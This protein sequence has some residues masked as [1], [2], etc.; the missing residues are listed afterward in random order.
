M[1]NPIV[2]IVGRPNVGK[3]T[4]LNRMSGERIAITSPVPGTTRDR[5]YAPVEW[6]GREFTIV[7]T[8]GLEVT[9]S[10][11]MPQRIKG[12]VEIAI[13]EADAILFLVDAAEGLLP[14]DQD[15]ASFLRRSG[16]P[17]LL[18]A[19][20]VDNLQRELQAAEFHRLGLGEPLPVSA[21]H[22]RG[23][24]EMLDRLLLLLPAPAAE[25]KEEPGIKIA[26]VGRTNVGK[27]MLLNALLGEERA[28]VSPT[29]GT[30][31]DA[32]DSPCQYRGE[33]LLLIDTAGIRRRGR[34]EPGVERYSVLRAMRAIER[35]DVAI[36]VL[37]APVGMLAQ[38]LH[39]A[40][41]IH[42]AFKGAVIA[43]NKWD[44]MAERDEAGYAHRVRAQLHFMPYVPVRFVSALT[45][46][47]VEGLL[48]AALEVFR[49]R[50]RRLPPS[51]LREVVNQAIQRHQVSHKG[52]ELKVYSTAQV[53]VNPPTFLFQVNDPRL[54]HFSY[55]RY[56]E[57]RLRQAFG[58]Q[59]T[60]LKLVFKARGQK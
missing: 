5:L 54:F 56:L 6:E 58:F 15:I 4:L 34:V 27:S 13:R 42:S 16:K 53:Q 18:V 39:I 35:S 19:N 45:G 33:R 38:D 50:Q 14:A 10:A 47:G 2:A 9:P 55:R 24:A 26:I 51:R 59:G 41:Y 44:L 17:L 48:Q 43:V 37:E 3:S 29:P 12:Q 28:L 22:G 1:P 11:D 25:E 49:E 40:G 60:P 46:E 31:R 32:L 52:K 30:T 23:V 36:L 21:Y 7:D 8:G 57:N 20:K